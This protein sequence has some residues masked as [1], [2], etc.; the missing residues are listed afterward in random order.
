MFFILTA[1]KSTPLLT[2][3]ST[4]NATQNLQERKLEVTPVQIVLSCATLNG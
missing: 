2:L 3:M 4:Q 1:A